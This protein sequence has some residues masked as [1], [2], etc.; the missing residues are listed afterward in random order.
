MKI[1]IGNI[2]YSASESEL[3][4]MLTDFEPLK[5]FYFPLDKYSGQPRGFA[6]A[7]L[8][9]QEQG[10]EAIRRLDGADLGGRNL[11]VNEARERN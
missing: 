7:T 4:D 8:S 9:S 5:D 10:E 6:F 3:R 1:Y 11:R 2:P